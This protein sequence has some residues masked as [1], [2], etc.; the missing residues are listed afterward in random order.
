VQQHQPPPDPSGVPLPTPAA[1]PVPQDI[2]QG[3]FASLAVPA[4]LVTAEGVIQPYTELTAMYSAMQ[5]HAQVS[6]M[7]KAVYDLQV[8]CI[9]MNRAS[10]LIS[11]AVQATTLFTLLVDAARCYMLSKGLMWHEDISMLCSSDS[12]IVCCIRC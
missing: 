10:E 7:S 11:R 1:L 12:L 8:G 6:S 2:V 9:R 4:V 5:Q 3:L